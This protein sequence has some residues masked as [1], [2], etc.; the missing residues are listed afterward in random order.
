MNHRVMCGE[1]DNQENLEVADPFWASSGRENAF[2]ITASPSVSPGPT[3]I[4]A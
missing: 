3:P 1:D 4:R 2:P